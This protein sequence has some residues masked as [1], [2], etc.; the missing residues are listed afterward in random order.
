[1][2]RLQLLAALLLCSL[3]TFA[4]FSGSGSGTKNDPYLIM[5]PI[6]LN[7][8]RNFLNQSGVYFKLMT[9]VDLTEFLEDESP[10]QGWQ[11]VGSSSSDAF[12]GILDGNGKTISGLWINKSNNDYIGFFG[13][14]SGAII[15]DLT[16]IANT[17]VGFNQVGGISGY[18]ENSTFS[19]VSFIGTIKGYSEIGGIVG[20][21]GNNTAL[22]NCIA[23]VTINANDCIGG[24]VGQNVAGQ[25]FSMSNCH[26]NDSKIIGRQHVGGACGRIEG[27]HSDSNIFESC[28]VSADVNGTNNVGGIWM[29]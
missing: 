6:Q 27:Y 22:S 1:M 29:S 28:Y 21:A 20:K 8:L 26:V 17:I 9:D 13:Y 7:Q 3:L 15:T 25:N 16:I 2:K 5:N 10:L 14:T 19:G 4:Q 18:S 23:K 11:P 24:L 12:K